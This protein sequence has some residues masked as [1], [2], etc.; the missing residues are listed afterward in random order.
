MELG[1]RWWDD[2]F[3]LLVG[4]LLVVA[5]AGAVGFEVEALRAAVHGDYPHQRLMK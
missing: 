2:E 1:F 4:H 5:V 3:G